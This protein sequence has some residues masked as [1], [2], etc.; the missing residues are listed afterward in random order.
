MIFAATLVTVRRLWKT[1]GILVAW[2]GP[3][4]IFLLLPLMIEALSWAI[5]AGLIEQAPGYGLWIITLLLAAANEELTSRVV[6]LE[7]MRP[8]FGPR[9][10]A[11]ITGALFGLQHLSAFATTSRGVADI[12][13]NVLVSACYGF[14]LAS[15]QFRFHWIWPLILLHAGAN[16]MTIFSA[17]PLPDVAIA[18]TLI[19]FIALGLTILYPLGRRQP[20]DART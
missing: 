16:F 7:R 13:L 11:A 4:A 9:A 2:R 17:R 10:A 19:V 18:I 12:L 3:I 15:F 5:P 8:A 6:V 20:R 14:A 1:S